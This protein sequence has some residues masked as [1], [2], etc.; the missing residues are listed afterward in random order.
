MGVG[1]GTS[2]SRLTYFSSPFRG[3][4]VGL[5]PLVLTLILAGG[6]LMS[7]AAARSM[8]K[9][10]EKQEEL[11]VQRAFAEFAGHV[12]TYFAR[13]FVSLQ[14]MRAFF[15]SSEAVTP[16]EFQQFS[17]IVRKGEIGSRA[18]LWAPRVDR[19]A[20]VEALGATYPV[21]M[22]A[23][24]TATDG[25]LGTDIATMEG[26]QDGLRRAEKSGLPSLGEIFTTHGGSSAVGGIVPVYRTEPAQPGDAGKG[27]AVVGF[28]VGVYGVAEIFDAALAGATTFDDGT[29]T[30]IAFRVVDQSAPPSRQIVYASKNFATVMA[31]ASASGDPAPMADIQ[32]QLGIGG[33][34]W[35]IEFFHVPFPPMHPANLS[36][37]AILIAGLAVTI[38][39]YAFVLTLFNRERSIRRI[40]D[41]R[42]KALEESEARIRD[43]LDVSAD[44]HWE[45]GS[46]LRLTYV[47]GR[48]EQI[49]GMAVDHFIGY[50]R[51][52]IAGLE[53]EKLDEQWD[54]H[55]D[56]LKHHRAFHDY[57][58][59]TTLPNGRVI[60]MSI[61]GK[62]IFGRTGEFV[63][64]R[65]TGRD[66]TTEE[67]ASREMQQSERRLQRYVDELQ[68]SRKYLEE[69]TG[70]MAELAERYAYEKERAEQSERS[71]PEF[72]AT[73]SH[74]IRT[75]MTAVMGFSD[76][77]LDGS[78]AK[79]DREKVL[80]IKIATQSLLS[81]IND[82]LDLSKLE[83]GKLQIERID[84][85]LPQTV[86]EVADLVGDRALVKG[87]R[88][89]VEIDEKLPVGI[90]ADPTR[91]RQILINLIGNAV[92]FTHHG[93]I[94]VRLERLE[95]A[96]G[97]PFVKISVADTGIGIHPDVIGHLFTSFTQADASITRRYEGTG[98]GLAISKRLSEL[99][100]GQIGVESTLGNGS[101]FWFTFPL[102]KAET[103]V[104][105]A[106]RGAEPVNY[107]GVRPLDILVAEDNRLNQRIISA[108]LERYGHR[109]TIVENGAR[110]VEAV[111]N[112]TYDL[113]LMDIRMPEMSGTDA[114]RLIRSM[115]GERS[116]TPIIA[117]TADAMDEHIK[118]FLAAGMDACATKPI[119]RIALL[120]LINEILR[121]E[122]HVPAEPETPGGTATAGNALTADEPEKIAQNVADFL[123]ELKTVSDGL[124]QKKGKAV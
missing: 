21:A 44:W 63:G 27:R 97:G 58:Y 69:S 16:S 78:L 33:R 31:S 98:L 110:A 105:S 85:N 52:D 73:M 13:G 68:L 60:H 48:F 53:T 32:R 3:V 41:E 80:K 107:R 93:A 67:T 74:E 51:P 9:V 88:L 124:A 72:L 18:I 76:M 23:P 116:K 120:K 25:M 90:K 121:E 15:E 49:T 108:M 1:A 87:V 75:P 119:D 111:E 22:I 55:L 71:K 100:G 92:K 62:P 66:V 86:R 123:R 103:D 34:S 29:I 77:L 19:S 112:G 8:F 117:L 109:P 17:G 114:T 79:D 20:Q 95:E 115:P 7:A 38:V 6:I 45:M 2:T 37:S 101:T 11:R 81:I 102:R 61:S 24:E 65:G 40:V 122:V 104:P 83:A 5:A 50:S 59:Q 56:D 70:K 4:A 28:L 10:A 99:M 43:M 14:A 96:P 82:I 89:V 118:S 30:Q 36:A 64:Y 46:D 113:I 54:R 94:T 12:E 39:L 91:I 84:F 35:R 57:R 42:T 47:S 26:F 106:A